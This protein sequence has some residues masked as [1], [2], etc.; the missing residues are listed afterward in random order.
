[1]HM[2]CRLPWFYICVYYLPCGEYWFF[3]SLSFVGDLQVHESET[4][5]T[6]GSY[7][8][9]KLEEILQMKQLISICKDQSGVQSH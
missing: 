4:E 1:M 5:E 6:E 7:I 2:G 9:K 3:I 8:H